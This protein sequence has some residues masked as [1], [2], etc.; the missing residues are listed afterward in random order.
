MWCSLI[1]PSQWKR[2]FRWC[3]TLMPTTR[4]LL[5][6]DSRFS[7]TQ[8]VFGAVA[9]S[10]P[11]TNWHLSTP[12]QTDPESPIDLEAV[13]DVKQ[14]VMPAQARRAEREPGHGETTRLT[15]LSNGAFNMRA[16]GVS[17]SCSHSKEPP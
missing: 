14:Q 1:S 16:A 15:S 5:S 13:A 11:R 9:E 10:T 3:A 17:P 2:I 8:Q 12:F 6:S 7:A 4:L